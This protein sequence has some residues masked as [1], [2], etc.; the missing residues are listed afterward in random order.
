MSEP[1]FDPEVV[2]LLD[3]VAADP[4]STLLR[5]PK[6]RLLKWVGRPEEIVSPSGSHLTKAEKHLAAAYREEAAWVLLQ[7]CIAGLRRD[8]LLFS[9]VEPDPKLVQR[10]ARHLSGNEYL[11]ASSQAALSQLN[12]QD[13]FDAARLGT[14]AMRLVPNDT[15][16]NALAVALLPKGQHVGAMRLLTRVLVGE[17]DTTQRSQAWENMAKVWTIRR[18]FAK[19]FECNRMALQSAPSTIRLL[20][21][22]LTS[23][24]QAGHE[25]RARDC[26]SELEKHPALADIDQISSALSLARETG[27]WSPTAASRMLS[28][29]LRGEVAQPV[30][31]VCDVF[32]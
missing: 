26:V 5:I 30:R 11:S 23:A 18:D 21:W 7:A 12:T 20:V 8:P 31:E 27:G 1:D 4:N 28:E 10:R 14:A 29:R 17:P 19:S 13:A 24:L 25:P 2:A 9:T 16:R 22:C 32:A 6:G 15:N 3:E